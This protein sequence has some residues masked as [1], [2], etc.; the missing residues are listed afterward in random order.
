MCDDMQTG[1]PGRFPQ[2]QTDRPA[3]DDESTTST[4]S[5]FAQS[6]IMPAPGRDVL[7]RSVLGLSQTARWTGMQNSLQKQISTTAFAFRGYNVTNLGRTPELLKHRVYGPIV[8]RH[9][10]EASEICR[11]VLKRPV[12]LVSRVRRRAKSSLR[13]YGPDLAMIAAVEMA[14]LELLKEFFEIDIREAKFLTG[15]SL[16]E[17]SAL[18]AAGV[19]ELPEVLPVLLANAGDLAELGRHVSLGVLFSRG[20]ELD[21][22]EVQRLCLRITHEGQGTIAISAILS[23]NTVLLLGQ[24]DAIGRFKNRMLEHFPSSVHL[25][26]N[27]HRWPPMHTPIVRQRNV[28]SRAAVMLETVPGGFTA[29]DPPILSCVTGDVAYNDFNSRELLYTWVDHPQRLWDVVDRMLAGGV[30]TV[31]HVGPEPNIIPATL[32][33]LARNISAQLSGRSLASFGMRT[34]SRMVRPWLTRLLYSDAALLRAP[35]VTQIVLEDWLLE[36][37]LP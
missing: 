20:P 7:P 21:L 15:Y 26:P 23:P 18:C 35:F 8:R 19:Y 30:E 10:D 24:G 33:R 16:G 31:V 3:A 11:S 22:E 5:R 4:V 32:T 25:R 13:T 27:P 9:L 17:V 12:N 1:E 14:Q 6:A 28:P 34:I 36:Q 2:R 37:P 29:P